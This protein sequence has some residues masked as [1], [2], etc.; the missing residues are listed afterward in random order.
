M[1]K[2]DPMLA[3][4]D[5]A[6]LRFGVVMKWVRA[7]AHLLQQASSSCCTQS[8][9]FFLFFWFLA[10]LAHWRVSKIVVTSNLW[11]IWTFV[12][13]AGHTYAW[14]LGWCGNSLIV[15]FWCRVF[16]GPCCDCWCWLHQRS[17]CSG[18]CWCL[19]FWASRRC[20]CVDWMFWTLWFFTLYLYVYLLFYFTCQPIVFF[21]ILSFL[22]W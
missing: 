22:M 12:F 13:E 11:Q 2:N 8:S 18:S 4:W 21:S 16:S 20:W 5:L 6:S 19:I 10:W 7:A 14:D 1:N 15:L 3:P 9:V 17:F